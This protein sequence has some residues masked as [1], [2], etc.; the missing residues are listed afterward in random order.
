MASGTGTVYPSFPGRNAIHQSSS[1]SH[2]TESIGVESR[3][4]IN[5]NTL[6]DI[7]ASEMSVLGI[8]FLGL[9]R[10]YHRFI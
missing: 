1:D 6:S 5:I 10:F 9:Y 3:P 7:T 2:C 8:F 4:C